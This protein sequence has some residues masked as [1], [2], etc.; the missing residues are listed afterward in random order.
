MSKGRY[1]RY[2]NKT[3][4]LKQLVLSFK[5]PKINSWVLMSLMGHRTFSFKSWHVN[6]QIWQ[7]FVLLRGRTTA[8]LKFGKPWQN[9]VDLEITGPQVKQGSL[10]P[11][12]K[13]NFLD[14]FLFR[15]VYKI[16]AV[17]IVLKDS[18]ICSV[19]RGNGEWYWCI[20]G[21]F[22]SWILHFIFSL[23]FIYPHPHPR[24]TTFSYTCAH[25]PGFRSEIEYQIFDQV[26]NWVGEITGL[27]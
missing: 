2:E 16:F 6:W 18:L 4:N 15:F 10:T 25:A 27:K 21:D 1:Y 24:P 26:W 8:S 19:D 5:V 20:H 14:S 7:K 11:V 17:C 13:Y 9:L 22:V 23:L 3:P 12:R